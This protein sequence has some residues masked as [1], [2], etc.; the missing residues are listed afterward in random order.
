MNKGQIRKIYSDK[1][2]SLA[3]EAMEQMTT[4]IVKQFGELHLENVRAVLSY[5]PIRNRHEIDAALCEKALRERHDDIRI[6]HPRIVTGSNFME[7]VLVNG[8]TQFSHNDYFIRE[9]AHGQILTPESFDLVLVPLLAF[10]RRGFRVG[11]GKGFYDRWLAQCRPDILKIGLSFFEPV[12]R[13]GDINEFDVP[14]NLCIT[15]MRVYEF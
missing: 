15:P 14:L 3:D 13:I 5:S 1:R 11:Y 12:D 10:D 4:G 8:D 7:A 9:P 2:K 6:A